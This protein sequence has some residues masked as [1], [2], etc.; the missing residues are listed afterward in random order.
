V[1]SV[2]AGVKGVVVELY[3]LALCIV[4][5]LLSNNKVCDCV[6]GA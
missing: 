4:C 6:D 1:W 5:N 3:N 2:S